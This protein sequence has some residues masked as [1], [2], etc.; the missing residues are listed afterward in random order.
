MHTSRAMFLVENNLDG[1]RLSLSSAD[2]TASPDQEIDLSEIKAEIE[3]CSPAEN[4]DISS[5]PLEEKEISWTC[6]TLNNN[7]FD[8]L[9]LLKERGE[10]DLGSID[11][12]DLEAALM[13]PRKVAMRIRL[14]L[15]LFKVLHRTYYYRAR[16]HRMGRAPSP[17]DRGTFLHILLSMLLPKEIY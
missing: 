15:I 12:T 17:A 4:P 11:D 10:D 3:Q 5:L 8:M 14:Q 9:R 2:D 16:L 6:K 7:M 1:I 13:H